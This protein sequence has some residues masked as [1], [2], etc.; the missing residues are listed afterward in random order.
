MKKRSENSPS[1]K[2]QITYEEALA[3]AE[4]LT[5]DEIYEILDEYYEDCDLIRELKN[6]PWTV[7][8]AFI[9]HAIYG[10]QIRFISSRII[11]TKNM[12]TP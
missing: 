3:I 12:R 7:R 2:N 5:S 10:H 4:T 6:H 1:E 9:A 11:D 8:P